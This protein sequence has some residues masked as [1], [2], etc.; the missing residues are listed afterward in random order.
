MHVLRLPALFG[1]LV[2]AAHAPARAAVAPA[3]PDGPVEDTLED[4]EAPDAIEIQ[5][6]LAAGK[7]ELDEL[8]ELESREIERELEAPAGLELLGP[9]NPLRQRA[10]DA[11][12]RPGELPGEVAPLPEGDAGAILAELG[13]IDLAALKAKYDIP[14]E[15]NDEVIAY[16]RFFQGAG[17]KWFEK[18]LARSHRWLPVMRPILAEEGVPLDLVYLSMI[19]SGF[20]AYAYSWAKASGHWQF[21]SATGRRYGL[22]DDFWVDERRDPI[23]ATRSAARYLKA[24]YKEFGHWY[25]AWSGYNAGEGKIRKAIRLYETRDFWELSAAGRYL[26][27]E[28]KHYVPKLIAAAIV[29][30]HPERFGFA[31][32]VPEGPFTFDEVVVP[33]ATDLQVIARAAGVSVEDVQAL[34]PS[35]RRWCTPP[36]RGGEGYAIKLPAGTRDAFL[37][38]YALV[39]PE[40][41]LTFRHHRVRK[42]DTVGTLAR[43]YG[44]PAEAILKLNG[45]RN[46]KALRVGMDL[47]IPLPTQL[48]ASHPDLTSKGGYDAGK[49]RVRAARGTTGPT[50]KRAAKL[51]EREVSRAVA[52]A[53][54]QHVVRGGDTLWSIA[55][56]YGVDVDE[57]KRWNKLG[58]KSRGL[59]IGRALRLSAPRRAEAAPK[60]RGRNG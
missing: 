55:R 35:L 28:T 56:K 24:L 49:P 17:R 52:G 27:P 43:T 47:I 60:V 7:K 11:W 45:V 1:A 51:A 46:A 12:T 54:G 40:E 32:V 30:K 26:R 16:I 4:P 2:L 41:R 37:A 3:P 44:M 57:L 15:L 14:V 31:D 38:G 6:D 25:L 20:S 42:G 8:L 23:L 34:N 53:R 48:A 59:Q 10:L 36:A 33:D 50:G 13:G 29:S 21:I 19:E 22:R 18:W 9:A 58:G 5:E 39:T